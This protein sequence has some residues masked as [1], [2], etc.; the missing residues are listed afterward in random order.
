YH[1]TKPQL[2]HTKVST[3]PSPSNGSGSCTVSGPSRWCCTCGGL[4]VSVIGVPMACMAGA[5]LT[6]MYCQL[7]LYWRGSTRTTRMALQRE[8]G[9]AGLRGGGNM[10]RP[11]RLAHLGPT[12]KKSLP[13][14]AW[15]SEHCGGMVAT[16]AQE[17]SAPLDALDYS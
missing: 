8:Q 17:R 1:S 11:R 7:V 10:R 13:S 15:Q 3:V 14:S 2:Q 4:A 5:V 6:L 16:V 12:R 9:T